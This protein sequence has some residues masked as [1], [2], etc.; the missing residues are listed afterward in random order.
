VSFTAASVGAELGVIFWCC[1]QVH[2]VG[3][4]L[5]HPKPTSSHCGIEPSSIGLPG[6][7][8]LSQR[9]S[10]RNSE[11]GLQLGRQGQQVSVRMIGRWGST[12]LSKNYLF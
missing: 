9:F 8:F 10:S 1:P 11:A 4:S 12:S 6:S 3:F 2:N 7:L 5:T